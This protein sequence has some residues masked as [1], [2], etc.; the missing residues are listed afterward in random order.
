MTR[1]WMSFILCLTHEDVPSYCTSFACR[2]YRIG[3]KYERDVNYT[4]FTGT[5]GGA[6]G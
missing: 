1:T 3:H 4:L 5:R 2:I 6:V